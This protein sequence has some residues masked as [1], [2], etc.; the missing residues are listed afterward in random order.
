MGEGR[1]KMLKIVIGPTVCSHTSKKHHFQQ[2]RGQIL[3]LIQKNLL[4]KN[5]ANLG[6]KTQMFALKISV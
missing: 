6:F 5:M 1:S 2:R 3:S 4:L